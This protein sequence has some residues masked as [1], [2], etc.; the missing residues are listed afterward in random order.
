[1]TATDACSAPQGRACQCAAVPPTPRWLDWLR[2]NRRT[3]TK[4]GCNER[5]RRLHRGGV[6]TRRAGRPAVARDHYLPRAA[7]M[8]AGRESRPW[9]ASQTAR[10]A[11]R[12]TCMVKHT[13]AMRHCTR[14]VMR[15]SKAT[16]AR[17]LSRALAIAYQALAE[18]L[19]LTLPPLLDAALEPCSQ[20]RRRRLWCAA[21]SEFRR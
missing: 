17:P 9:K 6:S 21:A 13:L 3:G 11:S 12:A 7:A 15:S 2:R 18:S 1:M 4:S 19:P 14:L 20:R 10:T 5:L 8:C 16:T